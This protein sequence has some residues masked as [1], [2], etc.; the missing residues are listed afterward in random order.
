ML[1]GPLQALQLVAT[2]EL[3]SRSFTYVTELGSDTRISN[4]LLIGKSSIEAPNSLFS[5]SLKTLQI[6]VLSVRT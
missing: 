1:W 2:S 5:P 6:I 4:E 3:I